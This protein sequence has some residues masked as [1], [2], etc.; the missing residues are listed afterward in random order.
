MCKPISKF[1]K[2]I[3]FLT[4]SEEDAAKFGHGL[5]IFGGYRESTYLYLIEASFN[6]A[7]N[8]NEII[9]KFIMEEEDPL[10][11]NYETDDLDT[12]IEEKYALYLREHG[13]DSFY[14]YHPSFSGGDDIIVYVALYPEQDLDIIDEEKILDN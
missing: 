5:H 8:S 14:F 4:D 3:V 11:Q 7:H 9:T 2:G 1:F 6:K 10:F 13:Y 12:W